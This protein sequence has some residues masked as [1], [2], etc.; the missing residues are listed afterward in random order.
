M[1]INAAIKVTDVPTAPIIII[2]ANRAMVE[3]ARIRL[4]L[5]C[6]NA[7][8]ADAANTNPVN[9]MIIHATGV[10]FNAGDN[11]KMIKGAIFTIVDEWSNALTGVGATIAPSSHLLNGICA[12]LINAAMLKNARGNNIVPDELCSSKLLNVISP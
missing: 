6:D 11:L 1:S 2:S 3:W 4:K 9:A 7:T 10:F 5:S 12:P 8:M